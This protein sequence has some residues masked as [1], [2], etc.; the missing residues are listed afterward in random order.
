M[1]LSTS[2]VVS[3]IEYRLVCEPQVNLDNE[4]TFHC[5]DCYENEQRYSPLQLAG[6]RSR[7]TKNAASAPLTAASP[8]TGLVRHPR[9]GERTPLRQG[10]PKPARQTHHSNGSLDQVADSGMTSDSARNFIKVSTPMGHIRALR[11]GVVQEPDLLSPPGIQGP[12]HI[13]NHFRLFS[14]VGRYRR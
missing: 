9:R 11:V 5:Y 1:F 10:G 8:L 4:A 3:V 2:Q 12:H 6:T 13:Q 14:D 7:S